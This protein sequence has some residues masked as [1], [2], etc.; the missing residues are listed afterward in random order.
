[1]SFSDGTKIELKRG[2]LYK[3]GKSESTAWKKRFMV[4]V[5]PQH[6]INYYEKENVLFTPNQFF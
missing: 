1:M 6:L 3:K 5:A 4:F 2:I